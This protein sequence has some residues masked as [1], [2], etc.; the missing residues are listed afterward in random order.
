MICSDW[1]IEFLFNSY[2]CN[3]RNKIN[4]LYVKLRRYFPFVPK[5]SRIC[6]TVQ[7]GGRLIIGAGSLPIRAQVRTVL[8]VTPRIE[9][10]SVCVINSVSCFVLKFTFQSLLLRK[11]LRLTLPKRL[12]ERQITALVAFLFRL[13]ESFLLRSLEIYR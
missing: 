3:L 10:T 6:C 13:E 4:S 2:R 5:V 9:A 7:R 11:L 12:R 1:P 8:A